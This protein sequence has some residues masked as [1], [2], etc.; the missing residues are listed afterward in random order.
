MK[1]HEM[2]ADQILSEIE[3][4]SDALLEA[5]EAVGFAETDLKS[6]EATTIMAHRDS[7]KS[8]AESE[9]CMRNESQWVVHYLNLQKLRAQAAHA[10]RHYQSAVIAADMWRSENATRRAVG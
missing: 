6:Y 5:D 7:G 4:R 8:M 2:S 9:Q 1:L 10:K 3:K